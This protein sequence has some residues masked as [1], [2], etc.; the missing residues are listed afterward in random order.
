MSM[1]VWKPI[2]G[3]VGI[4]EV[5]DMGNVRSLDRQR[6]YVGRRPGSRFC[7]TTVLKPAANH[8]G[9]LTVCLR[10]ATG[11]RKTHPIHRLVLDAFKGVKGAGQ[12]ACHGPNGK[13]CNALSNLRWDTHRANIF[14]RRH[15]EGF[16]PRGAASATAKLTEEMASWAMESR[17]VAADV[18]HGFNVHFS[19]IHRLR[20]GRSGFLQGAI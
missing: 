17:Q 11:A 7:P 6:E 1:E 19:T 5:S 4:Y 12:E 16:D 9:Y 8:R 10:N 2:A 18:A 15:Q 20:Q 14:D 13:T 3:Y